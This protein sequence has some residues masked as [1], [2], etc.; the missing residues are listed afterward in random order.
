MRSSGHWRTC[1]TSCRE[2]V[3]YDGVS[4]CVCDETIYLLGFVR[5]L[6][7]NISSVCVEDTTELQHTVLAVVLV[8]TGITLGTRAGPIFGQVRSSPPMQL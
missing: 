8:C 7:Y 3:P 1:I 6:L 2:P 4:V 5:T